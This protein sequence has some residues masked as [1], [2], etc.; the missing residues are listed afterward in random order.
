MTERLAQKEDE[1]LF[2]GNGEGATAPVS[3]RVPF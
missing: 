1:N 3:H 2:P